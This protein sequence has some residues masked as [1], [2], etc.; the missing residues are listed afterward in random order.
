M[1]VSDQHV[2]NWIDHYQ[3]RALAT[4]DPLARNTEAFRAIKEFRNAAGDS[5]DESLAAAEHYLFAR[6]MVSNAVVSETQMRL[7][8]VG[9]DSVKLVAQTNSYTEK[10][11]RHNPSRPTSEVS[12]DS[13]AWGLRGAADGEKDRLAA[14]PVKVAPSWNW[15]A[16]K[17]GGATDAIAEFGKTHY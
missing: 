3:G 13:I 10:M 17:F 4:K 16:M 11:M 2:R 6:H 7:M 9:Y 14:T 5:A 12:A 15:D 1:A 8:V